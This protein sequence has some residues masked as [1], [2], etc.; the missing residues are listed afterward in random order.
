MMGIN[1]QRLSGVAIAHL[2]KICMG[3]IEQF[4]LRPFMSLAGYGK[5]KLR[6]FYSAI[7]L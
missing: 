3:K 7:T 4:L 1:Q 6:L 5:M 2:I